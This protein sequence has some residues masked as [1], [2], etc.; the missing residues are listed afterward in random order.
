[1][2]ERARK[3]PVGL[4]PGLARV[5]QDEPFSV[6]EVM[7]GVRGLIESA[8][9][10]LVFS[11]SYPFVHEVRPC[12]IAAVAVALVILAVRVAQRKPLTP[13]V[14][15]FVGVLIAAW[16]ATRTG[17]P[18]NFYLLA[19]LKNAGWTLVYGISL[20]VRWPLLGLFLGQLFGE[21][22]AWRKDPPRRRVYMIATGIWTA[23]FAVRFVVELALYLPDKVTW[24]GIAMVP[25]GLPLFAVTL[26]ATWIVIRTVPPTRP[27]Q[28]DEPAREPAAVGA[29]G[30]PDPDAAATRGA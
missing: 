12:A 4:S 3:A 10:A 22:L 16:I 15:A 7:G 2:T 27:P 5:T 30:E 9:P 24:L 13:A 1:M 11:V 14:S 17:R 28:D 23:M 29:D 6:L 18:S 20:V 8:L 21:G 26:L 19:I 25:L